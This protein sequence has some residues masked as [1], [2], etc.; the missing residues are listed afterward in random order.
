[1]QRHSEVGEVDDLDPM[2]VGSEG[3]VIMVDSKKPSTGD[4]GA[5][6]RQRWADNP[7]VSLLARVDAEGCPYVSWKN[8][9]QLLQSL[10]GD[11]D[12]DL[13]VPRQFRR[14]FVKLGSEDGWVELEN[15]VARF[16]QVAH[17][18]RVSPSGIVHHLHVYFR[19]VTGESWLKE[20][21]LP[22]GDFLIQHRVRSEAG[23]VWVLSPP[24]QAYLFMVRHLLKAGS[25]TSRL[26]YK[27]DI[28]SYEAEWKLCAQSASQVA[29]LGPIDLTRYLAGSGLDG[30]EFKLAALST[31]LQCR[32]SLLPLLRLCWSA[33]V[34]RRVAALYA[35]VSNRVWHK[36]NKVFPRG[37]IV[38]ALTGVDGSGKSTMLDEMAAFYS[39]FL[40]VDRYQLGR[41]QGPLVE[42]IRCLL[43]RR[44]GS[45]DPVAKVCG[46]KARVSSTSKAL[47]AVA[48]S[49]LRLRMARKAARSASRGHLVLVDR[50]PT[51]VPGKMDGPQI[52]VDHVR[53]NRILQLGGALEYWA[54]S[55]MPRADVCF[56]LSLSL[57]TAMNRNRLRV[58]EGKE[59]DEEIQL[60]FLANQEC[61]PLA[62]RV[63]EFRNEGDL[64]LM[65]NQLLLAIWRELA[66]H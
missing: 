58:K 2:P 60:R 7:I 56:V 29:L 26:L 40:T 25:W 19:V 20:F 28:D 49:F 33:L 36:E 1:M 16:P 38:V 62:E 17:Y 50:W 3:T 66:A 11:S 64:G 55:R 34:F 52:V 14:V 12:L 6:P 41:P 59:T 57:Q 35:R 30:V 47:R 24:A 18:Y 43:A 23:G 10:T 44:R 48:L 31:S 13:F 39:Q 54:Y 63:V 21:V 22:V 53:S 65:R 32:L 45:T 5:Q 4:G 46:D 37:G 51:A 61:L 15:P 42:R 27:K 8:N 9:H